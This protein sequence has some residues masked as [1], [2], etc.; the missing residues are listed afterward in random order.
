VTPPDEEALNRPPRPSLTLL[1][2]HAVMN[3]HEL[4]DF[5]RGEFENVV[6]AEAAGN[7][8]VFYSPNNTEAEQRRPFV[9][10][11]VNDVNDDFSWLERPD[12]YRLNIGVGR[13]TF[14]ALFSAPGE[15]DFTAFDRLMPHPVYAAASWVCVVNPGPA[16]LER[17]KDLIAQA[18]GIA[19]GR[20]ARMGNGEVG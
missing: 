18:Y 3:V 2:H 10:V 9:T 17:V 12:T 11:M 16:T 19:V 8:L 13:A 15:D 20:V 7:Y 6:V 14:A 1:K 5:L 4:L